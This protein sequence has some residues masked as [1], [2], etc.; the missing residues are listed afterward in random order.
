MI[1]LDEIQKRL[2]LHEGAVDHIYTCPAGYKT[3]GIGRNLETNPLTA[4]EKEV[5][6]D[7]SHGITLDKALYLLRNDVKR[8]EKELSDNISWFYQLDDERQ[9]ALLD[10]CFN[11]GIKKLLGFKRMLG[12]MF[13]GDFRGA[14]KECLMSKYARDVGKRAKR[15]ATLIETEIWAK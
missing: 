9:Y 5:V 8:C 14:A 1:A 15:I 6:G 2:L 12:A 13:I 3:I 10:M 11:M 7:I 4:K